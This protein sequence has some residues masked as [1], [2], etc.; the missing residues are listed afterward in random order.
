MDKTIS[1]IQKARNGNKTV[2]KT[3]WPQ[4]ICNHCSKI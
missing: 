1:N 2:Y 3:K 4:A